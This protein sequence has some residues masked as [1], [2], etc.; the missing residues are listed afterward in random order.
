[1]IA[2]DPELPWV[3]SGLR[4]PPGTALPDWHILPGRS[5]SAEINAMLKTDINPTGS[6]S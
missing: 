6:L 3:F 4:P 1:M 5:Q 2:C